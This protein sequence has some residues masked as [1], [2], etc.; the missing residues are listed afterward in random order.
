MKLFWYF[1]WLALAVL[2]IEFA[3]TSSNTWSQAWNFVVGILCVLFAKDT[4]SGD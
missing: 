4:V 2:S 3:I 1:F